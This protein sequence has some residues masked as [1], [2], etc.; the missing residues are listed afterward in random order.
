MELAFC[1]IEFIVFCSQRWLL[2]VEK[3]KRAWGSCL[4][5]FFQIKQV[6]QCVRHWMRELSYASEDLTHCWSVSWVGRS[7]SWETCGIATAQVFRSDFKY[8]VGLCLM[9]WPIFMEVFVKIAFNIYGTVQTDSKSGCCRFKLYSS[10]MPT[11]ITPLLRATMI[12]SQY[13]ATF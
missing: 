9:R 11:H 7:P 2:V 1:T 5:W 8:L 4:I 13:W 10:F 3:A 6:G 12:L